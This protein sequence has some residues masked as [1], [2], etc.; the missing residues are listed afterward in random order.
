MRQTAPIE[1][2]GRGIDPSAFQDRIV[3]RSRPVVL[4]GVVADWP[5]VRAARVGDRALIDYVRRF[6]RGEPLSVKTA[7]PDTAG[8]FFYDATMTGMNFTERFMPLGQAL[9]MLLEVRDRDRPPA[10]AIQ[11]KPVVDHLRGFETENTL[12]LVPP[13]HDMRVW[14]GNAS[15][16]GTH[17]DQAEN[18][19]C[20]VAGRRRFTLFPPEQ[21]ANLY[22]GP[23]EFTPARPISMVDIEH[24]DVARFPR[25]ADALDQS[26]SVELDPGDALYIPY[27]W[28][29]GVRALSP[30]N[31]LANFW[32][33]AEPPD[34]GSPMGSLLYAMMSV[35]TLAP[36]HRAAWR[37]MFDH[38]V[39]E[40]HGATGDHL[41]PERRGVQGA[42]TPDDR[43]DVREM[44]VDLLGMRST[45][46][47]SPYRRLRAGAGAILRQLGL[48]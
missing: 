32:W 2:D 47:P 29:H 48:H 26:L 36:H 23:F 43:S 14:I 11:S 13:G 7:D 24:P 37:A 1:I 12:A 19:A 39:F 35:R 3:A 31:M 30:V 46:P 9:D 33:D 17:Y 8:R 5:V 38:F 20:V 44:I 45:T 10:I 40:D 6:D 21:V 4:R 27:L 22:Q 41:P 34:H 16:V 18:I 15:L 28:W 42:M 25:F